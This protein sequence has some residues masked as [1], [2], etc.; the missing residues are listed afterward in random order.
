MHANPPPHLVWLYQRAAL[1]QQFPAYRMEEIR[2]QT[3][4]DLMQAARLIDTVR[5]V[6]S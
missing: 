3:L 5:K 1:C 2:G 6:Q 4:I